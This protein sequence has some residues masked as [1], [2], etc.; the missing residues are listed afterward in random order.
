MNNQELY[1]VFAQSKLCDC[2][3]SSQLLTDIYI[4]TFQPQRPNQLH[5]ARKKDSES[6][7][8][9]EIKGLEGFILPKDDKP[10]KHQNKKQKRRQKRDARVSA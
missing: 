8:V 9:K 4:H 2:F 6:G 7:E 1:I 3:K 5:T 10:S